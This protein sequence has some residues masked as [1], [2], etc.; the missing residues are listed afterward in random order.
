MQQPA[1][2][3]AGVVAAPLQRPTPTD[4]PSLKKLYA[5]FDTLTAALDYA[6]K[7]VTG[8]NFYSGRGTLARP[9]PFRELRD[10]AISQ[11]L[12][13]SAAG[14]KPGDKVALLAATS[15]D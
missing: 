8:F 11:A 4:N 15:P 1:T 13:L 14:I 2:Q 12:G 6:A 3:A 9:L 5:E 7:G 10:E